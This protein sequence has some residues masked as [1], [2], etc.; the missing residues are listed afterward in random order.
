MNKFFLSL[1]LL[2]FIGCSTLEYRSSYI[3]ENQTSQ[4]GDSWKR[5]CTVWNSTDGAAYTT[6]LGAKILIKAPEHRQSLFWGPVLAPFIPS[7]H[8]DQKFAPHIEIQVVPAPGQ[9]VKLPLKNVKMFMDDKEVTFESGSYYLKGAMNHELTQGILEKHQM[10]S[11]IEIR[12]PYSITLSG[13]QSSEPKVLNISFILV[14][15]NQSENKTIR[16]KQFNDTKY[17]PVLLPG[18]ETDEV[19]L[20]PIFEG[21]RT[22]NLL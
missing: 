2:T 1:S 19:C 5:V 11:E 22:R 20:N 16:F 12:S 14:D 15:G 4:S 3:L 18:I 13:A 10:S 9:T 8:H 7:S 6:A 17:R 21:Q